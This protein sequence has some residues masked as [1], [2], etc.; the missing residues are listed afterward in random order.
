MENNNRILNKPLHI[1]LFTN[2]LILISGAMLG[3]IYALFVEKVGGDLLDVSIIATGF[4]LVAG[5]TTV[6]VGRLSD[7]I[8]ESELIIVL[9][10]FLIGV[11]FLLY[12]FVES[13]FFLF[14]VGTLIGFAEAIYSPAFDALYTKHMI[15]KKAGNVWG[16]WEG[17][18][19]FTSALGSLIGGV[20]VTYY[21][22]NLIFIIM[23][24]LSFSSAL[25]IY[26][27]SRKIL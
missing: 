20:I 9:G 6:L 12:L 5:I 11:G 21:G 2:A 8:K 1:L 23:A 4:A 25:Y 17:M 24:C 19:Y 26:F 3:P 15:K 10:Y 22:F 7:E 13:V 27:L 18:F 14:F 16:I